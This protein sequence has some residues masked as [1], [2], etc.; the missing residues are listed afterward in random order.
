MRADRPKGEAF[1]WSMP[2]SS[3]SLI[4]FSEPSGTAGCI[5]CSATA[6]KPKA[7]SRAS[8]S[9]V[10]PATSSSSAALTVPPVASTC[11]SKVALSRL[12][13][14]SPSS[15]WVNSA[16]LGASAGA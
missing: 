1:C 13:V 4:F 8:T 16:R 15:C 12:V 6:A 9:A 5:T 11:A 3:R 2:C 10:T 14:P 7:A